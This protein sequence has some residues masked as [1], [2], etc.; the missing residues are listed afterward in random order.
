MTPAA[1]S[2]FIVVSDVTV[3]AEGCEALEAAF[4]D[5][6]GEVEQ[7]P[8]FQRL[9]VWRDARVTGSYQ[10]VSWWDDE[11]CWR[12]YMSSPAHHRSHARIPRDPVAPRGRGVR[13]ME[14]L[15]R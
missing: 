7:V 13:R 15:C 4:R 3:S 12:A 10:M 6:L 2:A 9:E 5:R 1:G 14:L 11:R 8:G